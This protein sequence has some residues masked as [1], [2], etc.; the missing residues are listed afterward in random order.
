[1]AFFVARKHGASPAKT[2][3]L[4]PCR[5]TTVFGMVMG[6]PGLHHPRVR[7][8]IYP[9]RRVRSDFGAQGSPLT[10][11]ATALYGVPTMFIA[12]LDHPEFDSFGPVG[13]CVTGHHG[14]FPSVPTEVMK[15]VISKMN[16]K[17]VQI[18]YGMTETSPVINPDRCQR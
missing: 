10:K 12:E 5:C 13:H 18:A 17:E 16:M 3:W 7:P 11:R 2:D 1:M 6:K 4:F 9:G 8:M 15:Q 14:G